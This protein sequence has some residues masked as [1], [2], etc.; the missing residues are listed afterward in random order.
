LDAFEATT[1]INW[2]CLVLG[3]LENNFRHELLLSRASART[4]MTDAD[5]TFHK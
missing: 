2:G 5:K 3:Y 4:N 1:A